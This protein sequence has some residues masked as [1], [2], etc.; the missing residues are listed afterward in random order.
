MEK[1]LINRKIGFNK[2]CDLINEQFA[3]SLVVLYNYRDYMQYF[4]HFCICGKNISEYD[5]FYTSVHIRKCLNKFVEKKELIHSIKI[6]EKMFEKER[7]E[8]EQRLDIS[9]I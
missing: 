4:D 9:M 6:Q 7:L 3:Y 1:I 5:K 2:F 8:Y